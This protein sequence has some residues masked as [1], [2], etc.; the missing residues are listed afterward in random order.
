MIVN[1]EGGNKMFTYARKLKNLGYE[2]CVF[3]DDDKPDE[4]EAEK[5]ATTASEINLFLCE[6]GNCLER[7]IIMDLPWDYISSI[8]NYYQDEFPYL[9]IQLPDNFI[10]KINGISDIQGQNTI[11]NELIELSTK[12]K[13]FKHIPGGEFLG[14]VYITAYNDM[15]SNIGLK[16]NIELLL[17]WCKVIT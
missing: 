17:K 1:A 8:V 14:S 5:K 9:N 10:E 15:D 2:T 16:H 6:S 12:K 4:L 13:W 3:A 11:R 7:Q